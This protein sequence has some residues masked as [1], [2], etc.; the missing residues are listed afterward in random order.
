MLSRNVLGHNTFVARINDF[1]S[2][3]LGVNNTYFLDNEI[4]RIEIPYKHRGEDPYACMHCN[5]QDLEYIYNTNFNEY[6]RLV[7]AAFLY[8]YLKTLRKGLYFNSVNF[9]ELRNITDNFNINNLASKQVM[10]NR[11]TQLNLLTVNELNLNDKQLLIDLIHDIADYFLKPI[12]GFS[13][14]EVNDQ[15]N[16]PLLINEKNTSD[17]QVYFHI[18][19]SKYLNYKQTT[20]LRKYGNYENYFNALGLSGLIDIPNLSK[21]SLR[22][23]GLA[24]FNNKE[25]FNLYSQSR[26]TYIINFAK[27]SQILFN[28]SRDVNQSISSLSNL[29]N[30]ACVVDKNQVFELFQENV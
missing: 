24:F 23:I 3:S 21:D 20:L 14:Q 16:N 5:F 19:T 4:E 25:Y 26:D 11:I 2:N 6:S 12:R 1:L 7:Y 17:F 10:M 13:F 22:V 15:F 9:D 27:V 29:I 8:S 30:N 28:M 18:I